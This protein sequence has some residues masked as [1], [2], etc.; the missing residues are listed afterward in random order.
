MSINKTICKRKKQYQ[1]SPTL[2][3]R[4]KNLKKSNSYKITWVKVFYP[5][6]LVPLRIGTKIELRVYLTS[7]DY[8]EIDPHSRPLLSH[9]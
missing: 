2:C 8:E 9:I 5:K 3:E 4:K 6:N 1:P 7:V